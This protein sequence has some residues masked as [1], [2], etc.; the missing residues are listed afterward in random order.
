MP[1]SDCYVTFPYI[2][3]IASNG[4]YADAQLEWHFVPGTVS[5][6]NLGFYEANYD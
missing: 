3:Q 6:L 2:E 5:K 4:K 1:K